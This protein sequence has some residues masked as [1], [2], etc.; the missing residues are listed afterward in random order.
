MT[1]LVRLLALLAPDAGNGAGGG[2]LLTQNA[3]DGKGGG[4]GKGDVQTSGQ[5]DGKGG[6]E[7]TPEQKAAAAALEAPVDDKTAFKAPEGQKFDELELKGARDFFKKH[8]FKTGQAQAALEFQLARDARIAKESD[9]A[10]AKTRESWRGEVKKHFGAEHD[11]AMRNVQRVMTKYGGSEAFKKFADAGAGDH[12]E[13]V[14]LFAAIGADLAEDP[15]IKPGTK[16]A[17]TGASAEEAEMRKM[18][19]NSPSLFEH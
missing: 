6:A 7:L 1:N 8:G 5:G 3:G 15:G 19:P 11:K 12:P 2:S 18:F 17:G 4:D 9:E 14:K 13:F 10:F 16:A